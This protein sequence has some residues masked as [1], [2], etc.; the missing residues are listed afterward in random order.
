M[1]KIRVTLLILAIVCGRAWAVDQFQGIKCGVDI[2]KALIGKRDSNERVI[3]LEGRHKDLG[4]KDL[5][6]TEISDR[7]FLVSWVICGSEY[8]LL[9]NTKSGLIRDVI[10][11]PSHSAISPQFIGTC[12]AGGKDMPEAVV[13]V[14]DNSARHNARDSSQAK[15]MLRASVAWKI[16]ET[17]EKFVKQSTEQLG[18]PLGGID[19]LDGGP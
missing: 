7:L 16:D 9:V 5:G 8:E 12:Q 2:S 11:F 1:L 17:K 14:L 4:L 3:V 13:A 6:G 15:T 18:C 10:P 19:T